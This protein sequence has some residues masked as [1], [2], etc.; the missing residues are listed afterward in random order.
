[1]SITDFDEK[2]HREDLIVQAAVERIKEALSCTIS[3]VDELL[4]ALESEMERICR[5]KRNINLDT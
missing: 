2:A 1:M 3:S 5:E 4:L